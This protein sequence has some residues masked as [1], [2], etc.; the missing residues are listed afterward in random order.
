MN[1]SAE[2]VETA[3]VDEVINVDGEDEDLLDQDVGFDQVESSNGNQEATNMYVK[4]LD[5]L[6]DAY[7][8]LHPD[9]TLDA[10]RDIDRAKEA[11]EAFTNGEIQGNNISP[12]VMVDAEQL[13]KM[14]GRILFAEQKRDFCEEAK[15]RMQGVDVEYHDPDWV[16]L[17]EEENSIEMNI[18]FTL[19]DE[20]L[21]AAG[22]KEMKGL[23]IPDAL[24]VMEDNP[25]FFKS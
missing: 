8:F 21:F 18:N 16:H 1:T 20:T 7:S 4:H 15:R 2:E 11:Y 3:Y 22:D 17:N 6:K 24:R 19:Y 9:N 12:D 13:E 5:E 10:K 25:D 14:H 23:R